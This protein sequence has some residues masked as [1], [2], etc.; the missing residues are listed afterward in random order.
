MSKMAAVLGIGAVFRTKAKCESLS[1]LHELLVLWRTDVLI[2][3][4]DRFPGDPLRGIEIAKQ[5]RLA[6]RITVGTPQ[7]ESTA[8]KHRTVY[9]PRLNPNRKMRSPGSHIVRIAA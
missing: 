3:L 5:G 4:F 7:K 9:A 1:L 6:V 2:D 8:A